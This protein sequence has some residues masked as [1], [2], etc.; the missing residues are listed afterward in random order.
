MEIRGDIIRT[1]WSVQILQALENSRARQV[2][3][4]GGKFQNPVHKS[5]ANLSRSNIIYPL[6]KI[7]PYR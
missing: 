2:G 1:S 3:E 6:G 7:Q 4:K 5:S